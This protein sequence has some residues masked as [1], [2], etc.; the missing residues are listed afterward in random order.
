LRVAQQGAR[1]WRDGT[2]RRGG[3]HHDGRRTAGGDSLDVRLQLAGAPTCV[4]SPSGSTIS[5]RNSFP[6][7]EAEFWRTNKFLEHETIFPTQSS[8]TL[9]EITSR[10]YSTSRSCCSSF[11]S[12]RRRCWSKASISNSRAAAS[13]KFVTNATFA[14]V[15]VSNTGVYALD[16]QRMSF[17][18]LLAQLAQDFSGK[19]DL[20]VLFRADQTV[21]QKRRRRD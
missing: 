21:L 17:N 11:S 5:H 8:R 15:E 20:I 12:S 6:K 13:E 19:P 10:R 2:G 1:R 16:K 7:M 9:S 3:A 18:Q 4:R 14:T